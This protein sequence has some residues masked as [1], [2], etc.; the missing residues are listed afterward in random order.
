M[1]YYTFGGKYMRIEYNRIDDV[2][3]AIR[4]IMLDKDMRQKDICSATGLSKQTI[5]NL[6]NN[7]TDNITLDTL[8][9][10]CKAVGCK[11]SIDIEDIAD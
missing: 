5:S 6:L 7:R 4:H 8:N 9:K 1:K 10:L 2:T 3:L 11:L